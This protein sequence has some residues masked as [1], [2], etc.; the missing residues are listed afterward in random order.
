MEPIK[1][2]S[3][4]NVMDDAKKIFTDYNPKASIASWAV[5][6]CASMDNILVVLSGMS[7]MEQLKDNMSYMKDFVPLN[8]DEQ[9]CVQRAADLIKSTIAI[10]CTGCRYCVDETNGGCPM[11]INIPRFFEIYNESKRYGVAPYKWHYNEEAKKGGAASDC[12]ECGNCQG[13]CP[14][15]LKIIDLLKDVSATFA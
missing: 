4:A 3:L 1:G 13:H 6:Y 15:G 10:P 9:N 14:Q 8:A 7:N 12:V 11:K 5:R 2:G